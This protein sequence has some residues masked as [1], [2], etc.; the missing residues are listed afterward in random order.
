M[1]IEWIAHR[2]GRSIVLGSET[3]AFSRPGKYR[4]RFVLTRRGRTLLRSAA[5][6]RFTVVGWLDYRSLGTSDT[7]SSAST[8]GVTPAGQIEISPVP[9]AWDGPAPKGY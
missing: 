7:I 9:E 6:L 5:M 4:C 8:A 1:L 3:G 2:A